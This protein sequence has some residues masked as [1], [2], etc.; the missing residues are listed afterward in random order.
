MRGRVVGVMTSTAYAAGPL[1]YL[2]VRPAA[3]STRNR[4]DLCGP[5]DSD[6]PDR[7]SKCL[8]T[9][10]S[11]TRSS[12][13]LDRRQLNPITSFAPGDAQYP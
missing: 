10:A 6:H 11:R 13:A 7:R 9:G 1:G 5:V 2:A 12:A 3:R 8:P 4:V